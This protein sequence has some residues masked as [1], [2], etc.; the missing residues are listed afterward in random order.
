METGNQQQKSR[1]KEKPRSPFNSAEILN[2]QDR[3][4][5]RGWSLCEIIDQPGAGFYK[6]GQQQRLLFP[7]GAGQDDYIKEICSPE[8]LVFNPAR[9]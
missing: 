6:P 1:L 5:K 3:F 9:L 8:C 2:F 7:V 4:N